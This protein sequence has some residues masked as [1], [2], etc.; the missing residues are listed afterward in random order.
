[1]DGGAL[2]SATDEMQGNREIVMQ[3][4]SHDGLA[5]VLAAAEL[6]NNDEMMQV[7]VP[8]LPEEWFGLKVIMLSGKCC[9]QL[10]RTSYHI[11]PVLRESASFLDLDPDHVVRSGTLLRGTREVTTMQEFQPQK[12]HEVTLVLS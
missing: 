9:T 6:Y 4:I 10:V 7:A 1:M 12:L 2:I 3:A 5:L 11:A 8:N